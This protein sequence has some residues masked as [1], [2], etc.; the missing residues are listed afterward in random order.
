[1][2]AQLARIIDRLGFV[3]AQL[4]EL[5]YEEKMLKGKLIDLGPGTYGGDLY[6]AVVSKGIRET[7]D[8]E[9]A[10]AKL[11]AKFVLAHTNK[12]PVTTVRVVRRG[13]NE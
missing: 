13:E 11:G 1:M 5:Q 9:A 10:R 2:S 6:Q 8:L 12:V 3:K 7:L 4:A